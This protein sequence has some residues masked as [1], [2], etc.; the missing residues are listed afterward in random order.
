LKEAV[1]LLQ[2]SSSLIGS[3]VPSTRIVSAVGSN[4]N[5]GNSTSALLARYNLFL[6]N[7]QDAIVAAQ[8]ASLT[9]KSVFDFN[10]VS[11]N[12]IFR[13]SL[14]TNNLFDVVT[15][16]GL[17]VSL[18]PA[19]SDGRIPFYLTANDA[20]GKGFFKSDSESIPVYLPGE[21]LL[22]Q[23]EANARLNKLPEAK[24]ALDLVLTKNSDTFGLNANLPAYSGVLS[25]S[26]LLDEIYKNRC[27][28]LYM[29]GLKLED[30]RRFDPSNSR[31]ERNRNF[32]PYPSTER[33]N[34]PNTPPNPPN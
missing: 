8:S 26:A 34:N 3:D 25:Q 12:P 5:I 4:I 27:I 6:G 33:F 20:N 2:E 16:F 28:E 22:I 9:I 24:A 18:A 13:V 1:R 7:Y 23:A 15:D 11:Q 31:A 14:T 30:S 29:T 10:T 32:Y 21:M 19:P 17:P